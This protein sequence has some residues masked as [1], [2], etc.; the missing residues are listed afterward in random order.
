MLVLVCL[1]AP[2]GQLRHLYQQGASKA[3]FARKRLGTEAIFIN[4]SVGITGGDELNGYF[5]TSETVTT[6]F[7]DAPRMV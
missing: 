3:L 1:T 7:C 5:E 6:S 4:T 2:T